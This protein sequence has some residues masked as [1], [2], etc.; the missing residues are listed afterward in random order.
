MTNRLASETSPYLR[1]HA[2]NP[3]DW[4]PWGD[5][6]FTAARERDV[7]ILLSVGYS[8]CH[9]CH[10]MAHES[11][12]DPATAEVMNRDFVNVKV[13]REERPDV[14]AVYM[15]A[16]QA[17]TGQGGWPMTV[18]MTPEGEPFYC[19]T[20]FPAEARGAGPTFTQLLGAIHEA[21]TSERGQVME[22]A[23]R[24]VDAL[25]RPAAADAGGDLP[26]VEV[27]D[28][29][30]MG[31]LAAHDGAR[32]GFGRAPK[33][34]QAMSLDHLLRH[35][36][37]TGSAT[38][39]AAAIGS[40]DA[41]A[42]GGI[43]DHLGGG[44]SRYSV[45]E[46]WLVPHFEKMLYDNALLVRTYLH[47]W[48]VTREPRHLQVVAE[49][50]GYVLSELSHPD[51][52]R[53][54]A[55]DA[56]SLPAGSGP[57][58]HPEEGAFYVWTPEQVAD[59]LGA[60]GLG[61]AVDATLEGYGIRPGGN[62][63]GASIPNRLHAA[64]RIERPEQIEA[65]RAAL[66]AAR[67]ERPRPG[68]DDKVLTEW[69]GLWLAAMAEAAAATGRAD[70]LAH[71]E[72]TGVFLCEQLRREDGRWM[73]SWQADGGAQHLG[74]AADHGALIDGFLCLYE[75]TGRHRWLDE[76]RGTAESLLELFWDPDGGVWTTGEDAE[77]LV[78]R[79]RD[80][81]DDATP[82]AN[83]TAATGLLRLEAHTGEHRYGEHARQILRRLGPLAAR[84]PLAFGNLLWAV[85][86][87]A[88]GVTEVVVTGDRPEL[89]EVVQ[90]SFRPHS[91]LAWGERGSGPL[92]EGRDETG[93]EGRA[94]VCRDHVCGAPATSPEQLAAA[95]ASGTR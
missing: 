31:M 15:E 61:D 91:V 7:P 87:Q 4:Y 82:S 10:V 80:L 60:A 20:Y 30:T 76:A 59:A 63:E 5:E 9:W 64:G 6:A 67:A 41:M 46:H 2:G 90:R 55:E 53:Y 45:D 48:Q 78:T 33:F 14:D 43:Y 93:P 37:R 21:W 50:I 42:A 12:E 47:A 79:P 27:L 11:F 22:Q 65:T 57:G 36:A 39:L 83:S 89:V 35:H 28:E 77:E 38:A 49:T 18:F 25:R 85:G 52:G 34:P 24:L 26:G 58:A 66:L 74:Y 51:G 19:G 92:W 54:S 73:R 32:G 70:W 44:F 71:A 88:L 8:S 81:S 62:F 75:A 17:M 56:D 69:N 1:Q 23:G 3:V 72:A 84:H 40:L 29:A 94:Y 13:D 86:L 16:T 68:L 95:F